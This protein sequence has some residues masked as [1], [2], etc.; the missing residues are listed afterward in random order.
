[1]KS[2]RE[3]YTAKV[4][5]LSEDLASDSLKK[6]IDNVAREIAATRAYATQIGGQATAIRVGIAE[7]LQS[8]LAGC[9][10]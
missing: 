8:L 1:M 3:E 4:K 2:L 7:N 10:G 5:A 9:K 6:Q